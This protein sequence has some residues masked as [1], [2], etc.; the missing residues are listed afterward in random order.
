MF[1][2]NIIYLDTLF[3]IN[4]IC[5]YILLLCT[6]RVGGAVIHR[7]AILLAS[8]LGGIYACLCTLPEF[9]WISHPILE[10]GI[11]CI[12]CI[13]S[14]RREQHFFRCT[15]IFLCISAMTG[16]FL[17][18]VSIEYRNVRYLPLPFKSIFL[19]F[20]LLYCVLSFYFRN[21][22]QF[23]KR[24]YHTVSVSLNGKTVSFQALHDSGNELFDSITNRPVL[25]CSNDSLL[26]LFPDLRIKNNDPYELFNEL[27]SIAYCKGRMRLIPCRTITGN[28]MLLGFSP[29]SVIINNKS[30]PH[31]VAFSQT[32]FSAQTPYQ[33][34]Y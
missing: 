27:S 5:D 29:D 13:L 21:T 6:A 28:G 23:K 2:M 11:S 7:A 3:L 25:I 26:P 30:E 20:S 10:I 8:A 12:L 14:F 22:P 17:S 24:E 9:F 31:I 1:S 34:I 15:L 4:F 16:G 19:I 32:A 18:A 33:A